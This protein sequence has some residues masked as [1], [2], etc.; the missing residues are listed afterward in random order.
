MNDRKH[1]KSP[2]PMKL[3][4][5]WALDVCFQLVI[6]SNRQVQNQSLRVAER[7]EKPIARYVK[8]NT[9]NVF[10]VESLSGVTGAV[11]SDE[12]GSFLKASVRLIPSAGSTLMVE[13]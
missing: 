6:D 1:E 11:I 12:H 9:D 13:A 8:I 2:I 7:W 5:D 3:T 10:Q 4:I